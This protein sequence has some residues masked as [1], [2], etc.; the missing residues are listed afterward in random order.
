M[1]GKIRLFWLILAVLFAAAA[2][3][4]CFYA[5]LFGSIYNRPDGDPGETVSQFFDSV[6]NGNYISAYSCLSDYLTLGL[7]K[8]PESAEAEQLYAA[9]RQSYR[10]TL[11]GTS[12]IS[13]RGATQ[14]VQFHALNIRRAEQAAAELVNSILE[15]KV[16][17]LPEAEVYDGSGGYQTGLTDLVYEEAL[18]QVLQNTEPLCTDTNLEIRLTYTNG[19]WKIIT[20]RNLMSAL[21]GGES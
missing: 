18:G 6:R 3:F 19:G 21:I 9:L 14:R 5:D 11:D 13:G 2:G 16:A 17:S 1:S 7:E 10:Y 12:S 15:E 20:D 4:A 8:Q